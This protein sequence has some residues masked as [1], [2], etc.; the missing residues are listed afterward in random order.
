MQLNLRIRDLRKAKGLSIADLAG[1]VGVSTPH[2]SQVERGLKNLNNH[3]LVR[4]AA[5]L[6]VEPDALIASQ[7]REDIGDLLDAVSDLSA[8][9]VERVRQ[10]ADALRLSRPGE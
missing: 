1:K 10:F 3:L 6:E 7:N 5:A 9:D 2:L 4:I 8:E